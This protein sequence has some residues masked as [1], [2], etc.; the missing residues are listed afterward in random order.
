VPILIQ[1][2]PVTGT[3]SKDSPEFGSW[4]VRIVDHEGKVSSFCWSGPEDGSLHPVKDASGKV[5]LMESMKKQPDGTTRRHGEQTPDGSTWNVVDRLS[6]DGNTFSTEG[7][8]VDKD[9]K[10]SKLKLVYHRVVMASSGN[11]AKSH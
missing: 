3:Y 9:G 8:A 1:R 10:E 4:C 6:D 7:S 2:T 5:L 11:G